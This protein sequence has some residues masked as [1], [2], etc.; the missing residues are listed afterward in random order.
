MVMKFL[1]KYHKW[2]G[3]IFSVLLILSAFSG[4]IMNHRKAVSSIDIPRSFLPKVYQYD[5]WNNASI[6][7]SITLTPDSILLYGGS[8][9]WLTDKNHSSFGNFNKGLNSGAE[10][11]TICNIVKTSDDNF[12]AASTF[13]LYQLGNDNAWTNI[14]DKLN[15]HERITDLAVK[16]DTLVVMTRSY[17][18]ISTTPFD[19]FTRTE[20]QKPAD[21]VDK[22][23]VFR[24]LWL[25]HS[26]ELFG[27]AGQLFVDF[28]G[29]LVIILCITGVVYFFCPGIIKRKKRKD[30][31]VK[32]TVTVMKSSL[33]WHNKV[34]TWFLVFFLA[35][36]VS[37]M[38]L[39]P[40]LLIAIVRSKIKTLPATVLNN[41]NPWHD[42]LRIIRY[43]S[44]Y[45]EW[46]LYTSEGFYR[47]E[48][49][50][51]TPEKIEK[52]PPVSVMGVTVLEQ[53]DS[54]GW[55]VG[56]F[57]GLFYWD[58]EYDMIIDCYTSNPVEGRPVGRP[59]A[60]NPIS[61]YSGDFDN[62]K[63]VFEYSRGALVFDSN[64]DFASMPSLIKERRMPLWNVCLEIHVG[65]IYQP[66]IGVFSDLYVFLFGLIVLI[67]LISGYKIKR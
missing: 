21:Y 32:Q 45:H 17:L 43:D 11:Q 33:K 62:K 12:Y 14:S 30:V 53:I 50:T 20:L 64:E 52:T 55:L 28:L 7:G 22:A 34:G 60:N 31:S 38:F 25:L 29:I 26:G 46:I 67:I 9:I 8:G 58:K 66:V 63:I 36:V 48:N 6:R 19:V 18:Y 51:S 4:I 41:K 35:L 5:N 49:L 56:S 24:T 15:N 65:R 23:T 37:G 47:M 59:V 39:R 13:E 16:S 54:T 61:G 10:N 40:P 2:V 42:K 3:L 27:L 57:S 1:K 44:T